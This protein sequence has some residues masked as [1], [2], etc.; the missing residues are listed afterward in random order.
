MNTPYLPE[1]QLLFHVGFGFEVVLAV[2]GNLQIKTSNLHFKQLHSPTNF[3]IAAMPF[4]MV[5]SWRTA[6][7]LE[8]SLVPL[9]AAVMWYIA[10]VLSFSYVSSPRTC[11][12]LLLNLHPIPP[13]SRCLCQAFVLGSWVLS[14][15]EQSHVLHRCQCLKAGAINQH[16]QL[17]R[18]LSSCQKSNG[19]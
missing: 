11:T 6:G 4:G 13:C 1:S 16:P 15:V 9:E 17:R 18:S 10:A 2:W 5:R 12:C 7:T 14:F 3:L 19:L 8:Q